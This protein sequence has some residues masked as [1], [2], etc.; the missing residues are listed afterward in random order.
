MKNRKTI[1]ITV[2]TILV[3][4]AIG[5]VYANQDEKTVDPKQAMINTRAK[6]WA[7]KY[8][9][10]SKKE[11]ASK[12]LQ[13]AEQARLEKEKLLGHTGSAEGLSQ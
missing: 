3:L 5:Y 11:L 7:M 10:L 13:E 4:G 12:L 8:D 2:F 9:E 1:I 6:A